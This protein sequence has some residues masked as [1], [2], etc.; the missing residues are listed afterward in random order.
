MTREDRAIMALEA[1]AL[2]AMRNQSVAEA[3][4]LDWLKLRS[5]TS[6]IALMNA[7][8]DSGVDLVRDWQP[9]SASP[10]AISSSFKRLKPIFELPKSKDGNEDEST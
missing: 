5:E 2:I 1:R 4:Y 7:A 8:L 9:T 3:M 6:F 10:L